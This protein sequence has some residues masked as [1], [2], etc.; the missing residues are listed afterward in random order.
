MLGVV[1]WID[2][3]TKAY[4]VRE[5]GAMKRFA[6]LMTKRFCI[7]A[8]ASSQRARILCA[9]REESFFPC[10]YKQWYLSMREVVRVHYRM[11]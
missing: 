1:L 11:D 2:S 10:R 8:G 3:M 6:T 5:I 4:Q 9:Q 7:E